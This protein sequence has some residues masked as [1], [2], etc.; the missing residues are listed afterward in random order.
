M[1]KRAIMQVS[2]ELG[3][4]VINDK[5]VANYIQNK[6]TDE[7]KRMIVDFLK[8]KVAV[9][10]PEAI[11]P[12]GKWGAFANRMSGLTTPSI[13]QQI[14]N[15]SLEMRDGFELRELLVDDKNE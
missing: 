13:T 2:L 5:E 15:T 4:I 8:N 7:I 11:Q 6:S 9:S 10:P 12:K 3:T 14:S 1:K